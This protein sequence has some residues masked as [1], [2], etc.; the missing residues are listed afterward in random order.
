MKLSKVKI[1]KYSF[2]GLLWPALTWYFVSSFISGYALII[3]GEPTVI[4]NVYLVFV[5]VVLPFITCVLLF[6][7]V[8]YMLTGNEFFESTKASY[9]RARY[10]ANIGGIVMGVLSL[11]FTVVYYQSMKSDLLVRGY[12]YDSKKTEFSVFAY[13]PA[14]TLKEAK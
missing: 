12:V 13:K 14:F 10:R 7:I 5:A 9:I 1:A 11:V 3:S 6:A 8:Y 2:S 4:I